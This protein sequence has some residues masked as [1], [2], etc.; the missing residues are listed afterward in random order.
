M[1]EAKLLLLPPLVCLLPALVGLGV[2]RR[3]PR[4]GRGLVAVGLLSLWFLC[5]PFV[6]TRVLDLLQ[7]DTP[8]APSTALPGDAVIVV[9]AA[10][11]EPRAA[12]YG[13]PTV[14]SRTLVR[15]RYGCRL[16]KRSGLPMLVSGGSSWSGMPPLAEIMA[17]VARDDFG[18][19]VRY[20]ESRSLNTFQNATRSVAMLR[21]AGVGRVV[22]V[23]DA[24]HMPRAKRAF[25]ACGAVV[26]PAPIGF[27]Q[28]PALSGV[29]FLPSYKGLRAAALGCHE[30]LGLV[31]Q[32]WFQLPTL[33]SD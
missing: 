2:Q 9:L 7:V 32:D 19:E 29:A 13:G 27:Q 31:W 8:L 4:L 17:G 23:T 18:V 16:A 10:G 30:M 5:S 12:E 24:F 15:L 11:S 28:P 14:D 20:L 25:A 1:R 26:L 22:L 21:A 3:R 6:G 33:G